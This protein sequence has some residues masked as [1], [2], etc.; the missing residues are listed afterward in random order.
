VPSPTGLVVADPDTGGNAG[1]LP[2]ARLEAYAIRQ[3]LYPRARLT[4]RRP[5]GTVSPSGAGTLDQ[6]RAWLAT[7]NPGAGGTLHLACSGFTRSAAGRPTAYVLLAGGEPLTASEVLALGER[8]RR[9]IDLVVLAAG[10]TGLSLPGQD[11]AFGLGTAFLAGGVGSVL[12][13]RWVA[14][15]VLFMTHLFRRDGRT[16]WSALRAAQL[17]L[18]DPDRA[19]PPEMPPALAAT[20]R[21]TDPAAWAAVTHWGR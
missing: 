15:A 13:S 12:T 17:W 16:V 5:D 21:D 7:S 2:A 4:G 18:L 19:I 20:V 10:R 6:V 9:P 11:E 14:P 1:D 3:A 8:A